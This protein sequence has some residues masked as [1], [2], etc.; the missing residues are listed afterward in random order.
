MA[1]NPFEDPRVASLYDALEG[2]RRDLDV[3]AAVA[4]ELGAQSVLDLGCGTGVFGVRL[5]GN[6]LEV[7]GVDPS[8]AMLDVA[9]TREGGERV[10]W[11]RGLVSDLPEMQVD[12]V[13]MTGNVAQVFVD[14][15]EWVA[16]LAA[17]CAALG[18][19]GHLVFES[20]RPEHRAWE[21]WNPERSL[22]RFE[23]P[24]VGSVETWHEVIDVT[25]PLVTFR[26]TIVFR[27]S[28]SVVT[29]T[30]TLRF[31]GQEEIERSLD[32]VGFDVREVREA[33]DRPGRE[34]VFIA[35]RSAPPEH[36]RAGRLPRT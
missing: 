27:N 7:T 21:E 24:G 11:I 19:G 8:A 6:G 25:L 36:G 15:E 29:A 5:A 22:E 28:A 18:P 4:D 26:S 31:R 17:T 10:R 30:S 16:T 3:Y 32:R 12:L 23:V 14:D 13:T 1:D 35:A 34:H 2:D 33:P 20:R 9:R